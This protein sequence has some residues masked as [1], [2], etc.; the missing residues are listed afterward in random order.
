[1]VEHRLSTLNVG[2][3]LIPPFDSGGDKLGKRLKREVAQTGGETYDRLYY[4]RR[5]APLQFLIS[6]IVLSSTPY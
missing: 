4:E 5:E 6:Q 3:A 1:M 2:T